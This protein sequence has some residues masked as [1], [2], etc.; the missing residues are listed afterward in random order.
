MDVQHVPAL[1]ADG[2]ALC[3]GGIAVRSATCSGTRRCSG[4]SRSQREPSGIVRSP[5]SV[6]ITRSRSSRQ[7]SPSVGCCPSTRQYSVRLAMRASGL[8][9]SR[10][11]LRALRALPRIAGYMRR[12]SRFGS[13]YATRGAVRLHGLPHTRIRDR[14]LRRARPGA[15]RRRGRHGCSDHVYGDRAYPTDRIPPQ[16]HLLRCIAMHYACR[17]FHFAEFVST[18]HPNCRPTESYGR[19]SFA[20][21]L[22]TC[23]WAGE[24]AV[25]NSAGRPQASEGNERV[26]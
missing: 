17:L 2:E 8:S 25:P 13:S 3:S 18:P 7:S 6:P 19:M 14:I 1:L 26:A 21:R 16:R 5:T 24:S 22:E 4:V 10:P 20:A 11:D 9:F 12:T 15:A 23:Y